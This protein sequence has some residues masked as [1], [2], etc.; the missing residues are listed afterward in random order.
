MY[1]LRTDQSISGGRCYGKR[2][3]FVSDS[4]I[5]SIH[6]AESNHEASRVIDLS[7]LIVLPGLIDI[8]THGLMGIDVMGANPNE[9]NKI[10]VH[11]LREGVTSFSPAT[12]TAPF[13]DIAAAVNNIKIAIENGIDG[14]S[15]M[16][17]LLE[18]PCMNPMYKGAHVEAYLQP[19]VLEELLPF[20]QDIQQAL[21]GGIVSIT[22]APELPNS[23]AAIH[24]LTATGVNCC[25]GHSSATFEEAQA[26]VEAGAKIA[27]HT[28][29]AMSPLMHREPGMVG[30]TL[31]L[32]KIYGEIICDLVHLH[33]ASV[34][35]AYKAKGADGI[36]LV[37]DS[38]APA[39][40]P[41]GDYMLG[42][43]PI[44]KMDGVARTPEGSLASSSIGLIDCVKNMHRVVG[45]PLTEAVKMATETAAKAVGIFDTV[46]SLDI[47]KNA[48]IIAIDQDFNVKFVMV[49]GQVKIGL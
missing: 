6:E 15:I 22:L 4:Q 9:I 45:V 40:L 17:V 35:L 3:F 46:G 12:V 14:A 44:T 27:T 29:N 37:T 39:G 32:D 30:A 13:K 42:E 19:I 24:S 31:T 2:S 34:N 48:D 5:Q 26:A 20:V 7:G 18:G 16:G 38:A 23:L 36:V 41:D 25:I 10:S 8:H 47:N 49:G 21:P 33:P 1:T 11:K 43:I 28:Y